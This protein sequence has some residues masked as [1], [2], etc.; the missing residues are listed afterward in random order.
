MNSSLSSHVTTAKSQS[1]FWCFTSYKHSITTDD[2]NGYIEEWK[3][4]LAYF[5]CQ[6]E[7][8]PTTQKEHW[9][10][11]V[12][13][14][15]RQR[16]TAVKRFFNDNDAHCEVRG[17]TAQQAAK[18]CKEEDTRIDPPQQVEWGI[19]STAKGGGG[20]IKVVG[21]RAASA[22][23]RK[24]AMEIVYQEDPESFFKNF[25]NIKGAINY[26]IPEEKEH[27]IYKPKCA[28]KLP[29]AISNW[30]RVDFKQTWEDRPRCLILV[31][32]TRFGKT[33]WARSLGKHMFWRGQVS[34]GDWDQSTEYIV[35][36]DI[37]WKY[38]PQK[39]S[40][41]TCMG[42]VTLTDK[43]VKKVTVMNDKKSII[44]TN[45]MPDFE[46]DREYWERN[47]LIVRI[48]DFLYDK[49]QRAINI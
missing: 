2:I 10:C 33:S 36:D 37:P 4:K 42:T 43:Y 46:E 5:V 23:T 30:L 24:E 26:L 45:D 28:W 27:Y 29:E 22:G 13:F 8:C 44:C 14:K 20:N 32:P 1:C 15:S 3:D 41:L 40:I 34:Y 12:E 49:Q 38:I 17:G 9:Q 39:K 48:E 19:I 21:P 47:S 35:I 7:L 16:W 31:G 11:Y 6:K 25:H 18:Y